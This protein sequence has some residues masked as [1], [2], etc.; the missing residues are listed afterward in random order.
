MDKAE[1]PMIYY[2]NIEVSGEEWSKGEIQSDKRQR[3]VRGSEGRV[4]KECHQRVNSEELSL[5]P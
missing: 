2:R 5:S 3:K 4:M 1:T